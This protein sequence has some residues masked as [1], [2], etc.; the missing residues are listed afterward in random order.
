MRRLTLILS[1]SFSASADG[2]RSLVDLFYQLV[3]GGGDA[4]FDVARPT[5][6]RPAVFVEIRA[7][8][9]TAFL[10]DAA[11][12]DVSDHVVSIA[13]N[14]CTGAEFALKPECIVDDGFSA[15]ANDQRLR[16]E[17][18]GVHRV[19]IRLGKLL[20]Y[21]EFLEHAG[22][23]TSTDGIAALQRIVQVCARNDFQ[24][25]QVNI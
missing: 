12:R 25:R 18:P 9:I 10:P 14:P 13:A 2:L 4:I 17:P 15:H 5:E 16:A 19:W 23:P 8:F 3:N 1:P 20:A 24:I 6:G 7:P 21:V 11:R 22:R